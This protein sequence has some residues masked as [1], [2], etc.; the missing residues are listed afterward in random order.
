MDGEPPATEG[1]GVVD[2]A[3]H[4]CPTHAP[5]LG[6]RIHGQ[7]PEAAVPDLGRLEVRVV[8]VHERDRAQEAAV[9]VV[10]R[11]PH[12]SPVGHPSGG[13]GHLGPVLRAHGAD[14]VVGGQGEV[15]HAGVVRRGHRLDGEG[16]HRTTVA[17]RLR[18]R[19]CRT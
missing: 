8:A 17:G 5:S 9:G 6:R 2:A 3:L 15:T 16:H 4:Q 7:H 10:Q 1:A 18:C 13:V 14:R 19:P 12:V 11:H